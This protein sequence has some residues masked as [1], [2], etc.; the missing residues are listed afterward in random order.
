MGSWGTLAFD[1]DT[2]LDWV[3]GL[4]RHKGLEFI[5]TTIERVAD[6]DEEDE[7]DEYLD[8]DAAIEAL[9]AC[10]VLARLQGRYGYR[11]TNTEDVDDWVAAHPMAPPLALI[12]RALVAIDRIVGKSSEL[13]DLWAESPDAKAWR[14]GVADLRERVRGS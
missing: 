5:T 12:E 13:A 11:N 8:Q 9:A 3:I 4:E 6:A 1:N 10:E 2:A 7:D 14:K